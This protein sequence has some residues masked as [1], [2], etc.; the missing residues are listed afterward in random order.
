[1]NKRDYSD[2]KN[3]LIL[4]GGGYIGL[5][6]TKGLVGLGYSPTILTINAEEIS[7]L[8][9]IKKTK[10]I[11]GSIKNK[12]LLESLV[13]EKDVIVNL[14]GNKNRKNTN[15]IEDFENNCLGE[16]NVLESIA[17][18][19]PSAHHIFV[20]TREQFGKIKD[21]GTLID[22]EQFQKPN[23]FYGIHKNL[24][25]QYLRAYQNLKNL[26]ITS[27]RPV[28]AYGP[29]VI[30]ESKHII[31]N[32]IKNALDEKDII[33]R[34][35]GSQ[36]QDF[37]YVQ[38]LSNLMQKTI[39]EEVVGTYNV[40]SGKGIS[41]IDL[42]KTIKERCESKSGI[43][44]QQMSKTEDYLDLDGCVMDISKIKNETGWEPKTNIYSGIDK[45]IKW[46][47]DKRGDN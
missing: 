3:I 5:H 36:I 18:F 38:D 47:K 42:V 27:L 46:I 37:I 26:K 32:W 35:D 15:P 7:S 11:S 6:L 20:G 43:I 22:E 1:M 25:E 40:G 16:L 30:G 19:N 24:C 33:I 28:G 31:S 21:N 10:L 39:S 34:G 29:S 17:Y 45:T 23:S 2:K 13:A 4:G 9:F 8:D 12:K 44:F 41:I 14:V